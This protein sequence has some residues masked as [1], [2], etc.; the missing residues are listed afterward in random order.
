M[1]HIFLSGCVERKYPKFQCQA[2]I[3]WV[4]IEVA[5][6][7]NVDAIVRFFRHVVKPYF[8]YWN[9]QGQ[10]HCESWLRSGTGVTYIWRLCLRSKNVAFPLFLFAQWWLHFSPM[11]PLGVLALDL[12]PHLHSAV[13]SGKVLLFEHMCNSFFWSHSSFPCFHMKSKCYWSLI[14]HVHTHLRYMAPTCR[15]HIYLLQLT[16]S[17][18]AVQ[19]VTCHSLHWWHK[20]Q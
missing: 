10:G 19:A 7:E 17:N 16:S 8:P 6:E 4:K 5:A 13:K 11:W 9:G 20:A 3:F 2:S 12:I 15:Y 14:F 1:W 18:Q